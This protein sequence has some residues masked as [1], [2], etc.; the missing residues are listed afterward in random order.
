MTQGQFIRR[1]VKP[2]VFAAT[3]IPAALLARDIV[4]G[5]LGA[6]PVEEITHRTGFWGITLLM[7]TLA[8]TPVQRIAGVG[9]IATL[10]RMLGL[11]AFFY[12]SLHFATYAVDQTYLS[13]LGV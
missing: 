11:Y 2:V 1:V 10:R 12:V 4:T 6:N 7:V 13:G 8:I 3:L 5:G 9:A